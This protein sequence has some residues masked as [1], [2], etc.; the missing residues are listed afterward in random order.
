MGRVTGVGKGIPLHPPFG[1]KEAETVTTLF[2]KVVGFVTVLIFGGV[3]AY[4]GVTVTGSEDNLVSIAFVVIGLIEGMVFTK[5]LG[6]SETS[7]GGPRGS[8]TYYP[9]SDYP[10]GDSYSDGGGGDGGFS[11]GDGGGS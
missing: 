10:S 3:G 11:G 6:I 8:Q 1:S 7:S 2:K 4:I 5:F 9:G